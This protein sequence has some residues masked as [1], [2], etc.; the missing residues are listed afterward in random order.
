MK[1]LR[2]INLCNT[3]YKV[4]AKVLVNHLKLLMSSLVSNFQNAFIP[5]RSIQDNVIIAY[6]LLHVIKHTN[7][8]SHQK[9]HKAILKLDIRKTYDKLE[10]SFIEKILTGPFDQ[11]YYAMHYYDFILSSC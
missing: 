2:P 10:W 8:H 9:G 7:I 3:L 4:I 6:E 11:T 5:N 1:D